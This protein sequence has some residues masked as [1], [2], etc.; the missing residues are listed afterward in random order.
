MRI[1]VDGIKTRFQKK[2]PFKAD[3]DEVEEKDTS[4]SDGMLIPSETGI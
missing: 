4:K 1:D 3:V 2:I